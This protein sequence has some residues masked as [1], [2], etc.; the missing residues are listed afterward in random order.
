[1]TRLARCFALALLVGC[2]A[3]CV[4]TS[5]REGA[6]RRSATFD[7][8]G[9]SVPR[10]DSR[11]TLVLA[12]DAPD[13]A[14]GRW[15]GDEPP[16]E[17]FE[18]RGGATLS[19]RDARQR[20]SVWI[21][22][23]HI[24]SGEVEADDGGSATLRLPAVALELTSD[25]DDARSGTF[26][27]LPRDEF[28]AEFAAEPGPPPTEFATLVDLL[29]SDV[30]ADY[31][32][33]VASGQGRVN[34][35]DVAHLRRAGVDAAAVARLSAPRPPSR[36]RPDTPV[37]PV[38]VGYSID[39]I[40]RLGQFNV[41]ASFVEE[42]HA[43]GYGREVN[44]LIKLKNFNLKPDQAAEWDRVAGRR[45]SVDEL[46]KLKNFNLDAGEAAAFSRLGCGFEIDR[47]IK[48]KNF[49][50]S[51]RYAAE[52]NEPGYAPV[53]VDELIRLKNYNIPAETV[54]A[55]RKPRPAPARSQDHL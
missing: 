14:T 46:I 30:S 39:D 34:W 26:R 2:A 41:P 12:P 32:R 28:F 52:V 8:G 42:W 35:R 7:F 44:E 49:N 37:E 36:Q 23:L 55:L 6:A 50:I 21:T 20:D 53:P 45:L 11:P 18:R 25:A 5:S 22:I 33:E 17:L 3:G 10:V 15:T 40:I 1:M 16:A 29:A 48:L 4:V 19:V 24:G 9:Q 54:R 47:L 31:V 13:A 38:S 43:V 27:L 51:S